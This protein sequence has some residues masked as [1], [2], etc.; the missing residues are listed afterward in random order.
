[1]PKSRHDLSELD[2]SVAPSALDALSREQQQRLT[3]VLDRYLRA[4]ENGLPPDPDKL[5][6]EHAE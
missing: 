3:E 6:A 2:R 1:M 4:L 5:I